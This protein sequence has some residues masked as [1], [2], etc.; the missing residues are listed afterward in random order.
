MAET[1]YLIVEKYHVS[2]RWAV[3]PVDP[4]TLTPTVLVDGL[5]DGTYNL[6]ATDFIIQDRQSGETVAE[7]S[8]ELEARSDISFHTA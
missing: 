8:L 4:E 5:R 2:Q 3:S 6:D 7:I 1:N